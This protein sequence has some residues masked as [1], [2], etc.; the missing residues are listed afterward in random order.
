MWLVVTGTMEFYDCPCSCEY[1]RTHIFQ[2]GRYTTNQ[3]IL[4][5]LYI[6][7]KTILFTSLQ[8]QRKIPFSSNKN[9]M[10]SLKS[11]S[12]WWFGTWIWWLSIQLGMSSSQLTNSII[13]QRGRYTT[14]QILCICIC[15]YIYRYF[16]CI[17]Y[18]HKYIYIYRYFE[19]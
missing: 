5:I 11:H 3:R 8:L 14:N 15:I 13:F 18:I 6:Y 12:G 4:C 16:V 19:P 7:H 17:I 9:L 2:R 1:W 10:K